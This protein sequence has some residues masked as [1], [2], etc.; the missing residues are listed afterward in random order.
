MK[1]SNWS[2]LAW[3]VAVCVLATLEWNCSPT[4][5]EHGFEELD[6]G[7]CPAHPR[8]LTGN[9]GV[10]GTCT[11]ASN[12]APVCCSCQADGGGRQFLSSWCFLD[13][14]SPGTCDDDCPVGIAEEDG[15]CP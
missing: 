2:P 14:G 15:Y 12:C 5:G 13:F 6:G 8:I 11:D 10:C 7:G 3:M 1:Q 9:V 4:L